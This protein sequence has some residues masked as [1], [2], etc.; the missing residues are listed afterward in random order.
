MFLK[1][2]L[3]GCCTHENCRK[4]AFKGR[5]DYRNKNIP[6]AVRSRLFLDLPISSEM[7]EISPRNQKKMKEMAKINK[8]LR[9]MESRP[10][11]NIFYTALTL[12]RGAE[13]GAS[14]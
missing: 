4:H 7:L 6:E 11:E 5:H 12:K 10:E 2:D 13:H 8:A 1:Q 9:N 3:R 14:N